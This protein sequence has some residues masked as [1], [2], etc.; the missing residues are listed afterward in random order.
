M[1][2]LMM[3]SQ[4]RG[5]VMVIYP[6]GFINAHT[7]REFERELERSVESGRTQI[8]INGSGLSYIASA[9]L[10][11]IMGHLEEVRSQGG[12]IRLTDLNETVLNIF[13]VLGFN[14]LCRVFDSEAD[15]VASYTGSSTPDRKDNKDSKNS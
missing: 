3:E 11:V 10:G 5:D 1:P 4:E 8:V 9:G 6:R 7:V 13:E 15:A 2:D 12:D 14:H